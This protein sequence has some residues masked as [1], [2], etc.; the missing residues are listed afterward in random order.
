MP[1]LERGAGRIPQAGRGGRRGARRAHSRQGSLHV[2]RVGPVAQR[3][4]LPVARR[5]CG[6]RG[7]LGRYQARDEGDAGGAGSLG[8]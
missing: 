3:A 2:R 5:R 4:D 6:G 1:R 7:H 8:R